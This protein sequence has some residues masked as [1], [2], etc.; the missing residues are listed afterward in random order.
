[1]VDKNQAHVSPEGI[2]DFVSRVLLPLPLSRIGD[3]LLVL[4]DRLDEEER[5]QGLYQGSSV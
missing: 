3:L 5:L 1:M 4:Y 2:S